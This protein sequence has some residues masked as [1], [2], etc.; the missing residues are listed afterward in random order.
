V[1]GK[2]QPKPEKARPYG[3]PYGYVLLLCIYQSSNSFNSK[4]NC[5]L[6]IWRQGL[7]E[8]AH[9]LRVEERNRKRRER[10]ERLKKRKVNDSDSS[11][12][13]IS[14][15]TVEDKIYNY[16]DLMNAVDEN[17]DDDE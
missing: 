2:P 14:D 1:P 8:E 7:D 5:D 13:V 11:D 3:G 6:A 17:E 12:D 10:D 9:D 15:D 16:M 4:C